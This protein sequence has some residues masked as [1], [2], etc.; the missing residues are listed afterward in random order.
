[1]MK[2]WQWLRDRVSGTRTPKHGVVD[3]LNALL[4]QVKVEIASSIG[5]EKTAHSA[6]IEATSK[7]MEWHSKALTALKTDAVQLAATAL[8]HENL[9]LA[10]LRFWQ[11]IL[12]ARIQRVESWK[13]QELRIDGAI[14]WI[15]RLDVVARENKSLDSS[16]SASSYG[17]SIARQ[18]NAIVVDIRERQAALDLVAAPTPD[19][20]EPIQFDLD[21]ALEDLQE[22][23]RSSATSPAVDVVCVADGA[24]IAT[25]PSA[26][27]IY[28][29]V[30]EASQGGRNSGGSLVVT[31]GP[32]LSDRFTIDEAK[33][34]ADDPPAPNS[35]QPGDADQT[36][37]RS[38]GRT[39]L[40]VLAEFARLGM[41][42]RAIVRAR[43]S[44]AKA[45]AAG[46]VVAA[47]LLLVGLLV[48]LMMIIRTERDERTAPAFAQ[49]PKPD[50][51][52]SAYQM[53]A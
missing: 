22:E 26:G 53:S 30:A 44:F 29:I 28:V 46:L 51:V 14:L 33:P 3:E 40:A 15:A 5:N 50:S 10:D 13:A 32:A 35:G 18:I 1:M 17:D 38:F 43:E 49:C 12:V 34:S 8:E 9:F 41:A 2:A 24:A 21:R 36:R 52:T 6:L 16:E 23:L 27:P 31:G 25:D 45:Y 47:G 11:A 7:Q 4:A 42:P 48:A 19:I 20:A 39:R 37:R